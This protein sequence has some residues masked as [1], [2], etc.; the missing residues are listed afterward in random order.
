MLKRR[1]IAF[2]GLLLLTA[3]ITYAQDFKRTL[4]W[5]HN[6]AASQGSYRDLESNSHEQI[7][8]TWEMEIPLTNTCQNFSVIQKKQISINPPEDWKTAR[9][10]LAA[11]DPNKVRFL[12]EED[13]PYG[14]LWISTTDDEDAIYFLGKKTSSVVFYFIPKDWGQRLA[15]G[16][17]H[18]VELCGGKPSAF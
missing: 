12:P 16:F 15:N 18:T 5:M 14:D 11:I 7:S 2:T 6:S 9:M 10:N 17:R 4:R 1:L 3:N 13:K 8:V